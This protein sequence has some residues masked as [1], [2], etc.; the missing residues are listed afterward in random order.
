MEAKMNNIEFRP[1]EKADYDTVMEIINQSF[2]LFR[3]VKNINVLEAF[4]KQYLYSCLSEAT[5]T[6]VAVN[7]GEVIGVIMGKSDTHYHFITHCSYA[8][9]MLQY[10]HKMKQLAHGDKTG[11]DDY[12]SLHKI[13][14]QFLQNRKL[15]Y[16]GVLTLFAVSEKSR[17]M[18]VGKKLWQKLY[19]YQKNCGTK[20][21][22]LFTDSTCNVGFYDKQN[23]RRAEQKNLTIT[24]DGKPFDMAVF[25]YDYIINT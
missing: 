3:Y 13:Y 24:R 23:F 10:S 7:N 1:I 5:F 18:G 16:D 8:V 11:I 25:L 2:S 9:K 12:R 21:L 20:R 15:E 17:G 14:R 6:C 19:S 22:Y 4:K